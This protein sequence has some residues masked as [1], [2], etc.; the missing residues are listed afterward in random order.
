[1]RRGRKATGPTGLAGLPTRRVTC[2]KNIDRGASS[3]GDDAQGETSILA[4][5]G[6]L[7][8]ARTL[9]LACVLVLFTF[10]AF[11]FA[12]YVSVQSID[13]SFSQ[14]ADVDRPSLE[15]AN[16]MDGAA[17]EAMIANLAALGV[18]IALDDFG[19]GYSS[20]GYLSKLPIGILKIDRSFVEGI[21]QGPEE[22]AV[23]Q[24]IIMLGQTLGLEIIAEGIETTGQLAELRR[25]G[26]H[27]GQGFLLG[28]PAPPE[29]STPLVAAVV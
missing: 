15:A 17:D 25:R 2:K 28:R 12:S 10:V 9:K 29:Q 4:R 7:T 11:M 26:C 20:L 1:V 22:A 16:E 6:W 14:V 13:K 19:S 24:A 18:V 8:I 27:L 21:D 5:K 3:P 23:A